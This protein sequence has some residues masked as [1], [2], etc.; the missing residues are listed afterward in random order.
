MGKQ[1]G[2][3]GD[4]LANRRGVRWTLLLRKWIFCCVSDGRETSLTDTLSCVN[5]ALQ[6]A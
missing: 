2:A 6:Y 1:V 5:V 3:Q 4:F